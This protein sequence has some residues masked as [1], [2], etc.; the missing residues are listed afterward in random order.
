MKQSIKLVATSIFFS[1]ILNNQSFAQDMVAVKVQSASSS[2]SSGET[3]GKEITAK[4]SFS[5]LIMLLPI[6]ALKIYPRIL[7][8]QLK[9]TTRPIKF[10]MPLK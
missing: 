10:F 6:A 4:R 9:P 2:L 5:A 8:N 3:S 7:A 1:L